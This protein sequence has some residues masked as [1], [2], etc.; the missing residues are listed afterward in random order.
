MLALTALALIPYLPNLLAAPAS[1]TLSS[2]DDDF[3]A[4][5]DLF[6][7]TTKTSAVAT[8][9]KSARKAMATHAP[10]NAY[11]VIVKT[12]DRFGS[13]TNANVFLQFG[14]ASGSHVNTFLSHHGHLNRKSVDAFTVKTTEKLDDICSIVIGHDNHGL[15]SDW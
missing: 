13:G 4:Q 11:T 5:D 12:G 2:P 7:V 9:T 8:A 1:P 3:F 15:F 6:D 10:A 14:D